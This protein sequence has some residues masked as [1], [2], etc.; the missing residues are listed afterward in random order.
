MRAVLFDFDGVLVNS[1]PLHYSALRDAL[2]PEGITIDEE[3]YVRDF[4]AFDDRGAI[5]RA[6]E[7]HGR[8]FDR[9]RVERVAERKARMFEGRMHE[10]PFFPGARELVRALE[11]EV[12]LAIASGARSAEIEA[13]L[14][15]GGLR[16]AFTAVVGADQVRR[17]K[18]HPEPYLT[19]MTRVAAKAED[20]RPAECLVIEDSMPGIAAGLA[21][22]MRVVAVTNSY[23][24]AKL[25]AA[26]RVV[27]S[28]E[29]L[30]V[31]SLRALF[32]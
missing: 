30:N 10:I 2:L 12:P 24:A 11:A 15:A 31:A 4:L 26:H 25:G 21:A 9:E 3:S 27:A 1:E 14:S 32:N 5:R 19:A 20:L 16:D 28:L 17:S 23:P 22:G 13:L 7:H 18:P 6:L 8:A 29:E